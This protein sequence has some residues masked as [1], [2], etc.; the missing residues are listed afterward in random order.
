MT[1]FTGYAVI[2][3]FDS[4][5]KLLGNCLYVLCLVVVLVVGCGRVSLVVSHSSHLA[6]LSNMRPSALE[7]V[8]RDLEVQYGYH[9]RVLPS[10][11]VVRPLIPSDAASCEELEKLCFDEPLR[12]SLDKIKYRL[13]ECGELCCGVFKTEYNWK[14]S[15]HDDIVGVAASSSSLKSETLVA[16]M[17]ATLTDSRDIDS[18]MEMGSHK[19]EGRII[20]LHSLVVHPDWRGKHIGYLMLK[21]YVQRLFAMHTA[22]GMALICKKD[23]VPFYEKHGFRDEGESKSKHGNGD[24]QDM[25][26]AFD[27]YDDRP[28]E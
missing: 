1:M 8:Y 20:A 4:D 23:L 17:L 10:G 28:M 16:Q 19:E 3:K 14:G 27:A 5:L 12:A 21:D 2:S 24:W 26:L 13:N 15:D 9:E 6:Y 18:A 7:S 11:F 25:Y 22:D